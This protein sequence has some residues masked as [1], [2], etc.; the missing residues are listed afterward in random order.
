M[1]TYA[2]LAALKGELGIPDASTAQDAQLAL[3][4]VAGAAWV[5]HRRGI[6]PTEGDDTWTGDP[7]ELVLEEDAPA[8]VVAAAI[9]AAVRFYKSPDVPFGVAGGLGDLA[10][11]VSRTIPEAEV[12]LLGHRSA[13]GIG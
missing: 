11:Y 4:L 10:V 13:W 3:A 6:E 2:S 9:V 7:D 12:L 1:R 5:D 8:G